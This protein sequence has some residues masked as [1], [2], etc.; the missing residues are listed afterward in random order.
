MEKLA[1]IQGYPLY[2]ISNQGIVYTSNEKSNWASVKSLKSIVHN[3]SGYS[4]VNLYSYNNGKKQMKQFRIHQLVAMHFLE[5][6][7]NKPLINH[8]NGNKQDNRAENLE[9]C[10]H[11]ENMIHAYKTGLHLQPKG[12]K[13]TKL[14]QDLVCKIRNEKKE[15][16][17]SNYNLSKKYNVSEATIA[18]LINKKSWIWV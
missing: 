15:N 5:N 1:T 9:W 14:N 16:L 13:T 12:V 8:K 17:T 6:P 10:N 2:Q 11:S 18:N 3:R 4:L 7:N